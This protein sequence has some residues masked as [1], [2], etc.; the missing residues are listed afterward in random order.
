MLCKEVE[1]E[2]ARMLFLGKTRMDIIAT[3]IEQLDACAVFQGQQSIHF[4]R[5]IIRLYASG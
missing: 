1:D 2:E 4:M 5:S 3:V